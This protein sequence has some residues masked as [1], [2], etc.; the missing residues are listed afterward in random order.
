MA[1]FVYLFAFPAFWMVCSTNGQMVPSLEANGPNVNIQAASGGVVSLG[2]VG[3]PSCNSSGLCGLLDLVATMSSQLSSAQS[4]ISQISGTV[5]S[6]TSS[7]I[8]NAIGR[9]E[10]SGNYS[11]P[12]NSAILLGAIDDTDVVTYTIRLQGCRGSVGEETGTLSV[13]WLNDGTVTDT[14][15]SHAYAVTRRGAFQHMINL[16]TMRV[17]GTTRV[18]VYLRPGPD[19]GL[20]SQDANGN[21]VP[22]CTIANPTWSAS[23][24]SL[25]SGST[26]FMLDPTTAMPLS[27][28]PQFSNTTALTVTS[29]VAETV[30][31]LKTGFL[32]LDNVTDTI[33]L[34]QMATNDVLTMNVIFTHCGARGG[35]KVTFV[36]KT[37]Q[38]RARIA[39][40][41]AY[42]IS[43]KNQD[44]GIPLLSDM[45]NFYA[46]RIN[47]NQV[48]LYMDVEPFPQTYC[49]GV[50]ATRS[51]KYHLE[52]ISA[53]GSFDPDA[54]VVFDRADFD[55]VSVRLMG[56]EVDGNNPWSPADSCTSLYEATRNTNNGWFYVLDPTRT[57]SSFRAARLVQ[58]RIN[59]TATGGQRPFKVDAWGY[60]RVRQRTTWA[61]AR[62]VCQTQYGGDL[63]SF[64]NEIKLDSLM[65]EVGQPGI[66]GNTRYWIGLQR[67][68][69]RWTAGPR[70]DNAF[71]WSDGTS[72]QGLD[73]HWM[74]GEPDGSVTQ[75]C[76]V[77]VRTQDSGQRFSRSWPGTE[78]SIAMAPCAAMSANRRGFICFGKLP[79]LAYG[80]G[81]L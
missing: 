26:A 31:G 53:S 42:V 23:F 79:V 68:V 61:S 25:Q 14:V 29:T 75:N 71:Y 64:N 19:C 2:S 17:P 50:N 8:A 6:L 80:V 72:V 55:L 58:C 81:G 57:R 39:G 35:M 4:T 77:L 41:E 5:G 13:Q 18:L 9:F 16:Y 36:S 32:P 56:R 37:L 54:S 7:S 46:K 73:T 44:D 74:P 30:T 1:R 45:V 28:I 59:R 49:S 70:G 33:S 65:A 21:C 60:I 3:G 27:T 51:H 78:A 24:Q 20:N 76:G 10:A 22:P 47:G 38:R 40:V 69:T 11:D 12:D 48:F 52:F 15:R 43:S 66:P 34:G 67:N 63:A 62:Q